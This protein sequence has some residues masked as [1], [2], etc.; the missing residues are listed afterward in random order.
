MRLSLSISLSLVVS[1]V[2]VSSPVAFADQVAPSPDPA[3]HS[4]PDPAPAPSPVVT[5]AATTKEATS[6]KS[7]SREHLN[8]QK[9]SGTP[10]YKSR[11]LATGLAVGGTVAAWAIEAGGLAVAISEENDKLAGSMLLSGFTL[12]L[13]A[14]ST[15]H[16]YAGK[17]LHA[18]LFSTGRALGVM[19]VVAGSLDNVVPACFDSCSGDEDRGAGGA[20]LIAGG[21]VLAAGLGIYDWMTAADAVDDYNREKAKQR[22]VSVSLLPTI[23]DHGGGLAAVGTF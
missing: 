8:V 12:S 6:V 5:L 7:A 2:V 3:H 13:I 16:L 10:G 11:N 14:P 21:I 20:A 1:S 15:G 19:M 18:A 22:G 4:A 23:A 9:L 17:Y